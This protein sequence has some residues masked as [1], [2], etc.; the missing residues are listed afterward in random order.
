[1]WECLSVWVREWDSKRVS[2]CE[3]ERVRERMSACTSV[4]CDCL[5]KFIPGWMTKYTFSHS[6]LLLLISW[7]Y[8]IQGYSNWPFRNGE[9]YRFRNMGKTVDNSKQERNWRAK[10]PTQLFKNPKKITRCRIFTKIRYKIRCLARLYIPDSVLKHKRV[11]I[12]YQ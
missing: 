6:V 5:T 12:L 7:T 9:Y 2:V 3:S 4:C 11:T 8:C 1:M 10:K